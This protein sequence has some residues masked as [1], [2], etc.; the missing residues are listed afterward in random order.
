MEPSEPFKC[1]RCGK[2]IPLPTLDEDGVL[3]LDIWAQ[4]CLLWDE[5]TKTGYQPNEVETDYLSFCTECR[6]EVIIQWKA[7]V[8]AVTKERR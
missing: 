1:D 3:T 8:G 7:F 2:E 4:N 6:Q 5:D